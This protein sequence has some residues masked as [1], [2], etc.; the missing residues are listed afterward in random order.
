MKTGVTATPRLSRVS[1]SAGVVTA[2]TV[3]AGQ[4]ASISVSDGGYTVST[5]VYTYT[6]TAP[7]TLTI[8]VPSS[9]TPTAIPTST[10]FK[11]TATANINGNSA[12]DISN[13]VVWSSSSTS[14]AT[15]DASGNV[16]TLTTAGNF[17]I[18]ATAYLGSSATNSTITATS[19]SVTVL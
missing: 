16:T 10:T 15:V 12:Q 17:T 1:V 11:L 3:T 2:E 8:N 5:A 14:L 4:N 19:T 18:T 6:G 9:I 13:Y 7:S